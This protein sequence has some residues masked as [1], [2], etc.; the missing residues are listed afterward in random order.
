MSPRRGS[1]VRGASLLRERGVS[2]AEEGVIV[3]WEGRHRGLELEF[4]LP[5]SRNVL[6]TFQTFC[7]D[8]VQLAQTVVQFANF[9][10]QA[11]KRG[12]LGCS[13]GCFMFVHIP[14]RGL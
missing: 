9:Q 11:R 7:P 5:T 14:K 10:V 12:V 8:G 6:S 4:F 2:T 3:A 1:G 13:W